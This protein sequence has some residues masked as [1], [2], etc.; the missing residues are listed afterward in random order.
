MLGGLPILSPSEP[1]HQRDDPQLAER[2]DL[3]PIPS[4]ILGRPI[5][6]S[7]QQELYRHRSGDRRYRFGGRW[8]ERQ[9]SERVMPKKVP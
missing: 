5:P 3:F 4:P 1:L 8:V 6:A 9:K 2:L 7:G